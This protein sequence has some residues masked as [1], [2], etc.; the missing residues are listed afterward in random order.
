MR[1]GDFFDCHRQYDEELGKLESTASLRS[2]AQP[3]PDS[4]PEVS[5]TGAFFS[6]NTN[7]NIILC[8]ERSDMLHAFY[9]SQSSPTTRVR[10]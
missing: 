3:A 7:T 1:G 9:S 10:S 8:A 6:F 4:D 5:M 2:F